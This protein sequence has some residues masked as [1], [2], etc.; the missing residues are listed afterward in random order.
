MGDARAEI[1]ALVFGYAER[2]DSGDFAGV[3][4]L[5]DGATYRSGEGPALEGTAAVEG[6][7]RRLVILHADGT[8]RTRHLTTNLV[9][10]VEPSG[11]AAR[12]RSSFCVLQA[13][14]GFPL[15]AIVAGRYQD[16][17]ARRDGAWRFAERHVTVELVGDVSRHLRGRPLGG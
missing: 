9:V 2:M 11:D 15:Q 13:L 10:E 16:R 4:A 12:A 8:P 17:F 3:G 6:A 7:L 5:F 14:E 1:E